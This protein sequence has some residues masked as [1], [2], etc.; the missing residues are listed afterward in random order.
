MKRLIALVCAAMAFASDEGLLL[1]WKFDEG[2]GSAKDSSPN[3]LNGTIAGKYVRVGKGYALSLSGDSKNGVLVVPPADKQFGRSS[4]SYDLWVRPAAFAKQRRLI[5]FGKCFPAY[6]LTSD[7]SETGSFSFGGAA[8]NESGKYI[9]AGAGAETKLTVGAWTHI[10]GVFDRESKAVKIFV[11]GKL[12]GKS[13]IPDAFNNTD[14]SCEKGIGVGLWQAFDGAID[15]MRVFLR[16]L[17]DE[18]IVARYAET[19]GA[20][21]STGDVMKLIKASSQY[22]VSPEG[23]DDWSGTIA[24]PSKDGKDGPFATLDGARDT[25]RALKTKGQLPAGTL[26]VDIR[27]GTYARTESFTLTAADSGTKDAP[28]VYRAAKGDDV[29]I[30]G[31]TMIAPKAFTPLTDDALLSR[32]DASAR[33][34]VRV[35]DLKANDVD[36]TGQFLTR[37][38]GFPSVSELYFNDKRMTL[39]RWPNNAWTTIKRI[40]DSGTTPQGPEKDRRGG[41]FTYDGDRPSRWN[42]ENGVWLQGYWC[43]DWADE[44]IKVRSIDTEKSEIALSQ[45]HNYTI[46]QGNP[47][48]RRYYAVNVFEELDSPG[49]Y[50]IDRTAGKLF[51]W[52][53]E[54]KDNSRIVISTLNEPIV[55]FREASHVTLRGVTVEAGISDGIFVTGGSGV[56][57]EGCTVRNVRTIGIRIDGGTS[58]TIYTCDVHDIGSGGIILG[59]GDRTNLIPAGHEAVNNHIWGFARH[60]LC[61]ANGIGFAGVGNRAANNIIHDAPHQAI[62]VSGNDHVFENNIIYDVCMASDDAGAFYKGRNPS[63][64]NNM[65]RNNFWHHIGSPMGHG[66]AAIY[67]DDGDGGDFVI[68]NIFLRCGDPGKGSFGTVFNHGGHDNTAENN[69]F[70]ECKR[71][72][73]SAPWNDKRWKD[74]VNAELWQT[75]LTKDV[76]IRKPPYTTRYPLLEGFMDPQ[77]GQIRSNHSSKNVLVMCADVKSGNWEFDSNEN[78]ITESD[79]GFVNAAK[80]DFRLKPDSIVYKT[81]PDF[82]P[83]PFEKIGPFADALRPSVPKAVWNYPPPK[84]LPPL[85]SAA[86]TATVKDGP[87]PEFTAKRTSSSIT[88]DGTIDASEWGDDVLVL[89][90]NYNGAKADRQSRAWIRYDDT[91]IYIAVESDIQPGTKLD[92]NSWGRNDAVEIS[93]RALRGKDRTPITVFRGFGNGY[94]QFGA[95]KN[96]SDEPDYTDPHGA[97]FK[98]A[99]KDERTWCAEFSLPF[100]LFDIDPAKDVRCAFNITVRKTADD[101]WLMWEGTRGNSFNVDNAGVLNFK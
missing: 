38:I 36:D 65:I 35:L 23:N 24:S 22:F 44:V 57:I 68:G 101:L 8:K 73:G 82:K 60:K 42:T 32:L 27:R 50:Y 16:T 1:H 76:D 28:I 10:A 77:P 99:R 55:A 37:F 63:C 88:A 5:E 33:G 100:A 58:H 39:A 14:L 18:E 61:Y 30:I 19:K 92:G 6:Y 26:T 56:R 86:S 51:F 53:P 46:R 25:I 15:E 67:F 2:K 62:G 12:E 7:V 9:G 66:N 4:I 94:L 64:R 85:K 75:R 87:M 79:P 17:T 78:I 20:Y 59:G 83:I 91:R 43:F 89:A 31:G 72:L 49:E 96:A 97:V 48:P 13:A 93:L 45:P 90:Q 54:M 40:I 70:I 3:G 41:T 95:T 69:I 11:N 21:E 81:L 98:A 71:P 80:G 52:P 34:Q 47:S 29:R 84:Q 74:Y